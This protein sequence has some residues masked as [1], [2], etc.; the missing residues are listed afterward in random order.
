[1]P[2]LNELR[3]QVCEANRYLGRTG[4]VQLTWGNVSGVDRARGVFVIKPSGVPYPQLESKHMVVISLADGRVVSGDMNPSSDTP[5]HLALYQAFPD[6]GG[7]TH[8]H[9]EFATMFAQAHR[10][11]PCLGT[12]HADHFHGPVPL[13]RQL[14]QAEV[15]GDYEANTGKVIVERFKGLTASHVPGVLVAGHGVFTWGRNASESVK[16]AVATETIAKM[17]FG[18]LLMNPASKPIPDYLLN[19]HFLRKHGPNATYGQR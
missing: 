1:M 10:E 15:D 12:T 2:G 13:T 9:S 18:S 19:R 3:E 6:I 11:I 17:A 16:N 7:I 4:L 8:T 14:T 5:T